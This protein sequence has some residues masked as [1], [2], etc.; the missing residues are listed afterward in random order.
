[1][2]CLAGTALLFSACSEGDNVIDE[3][4]DNETRGGVIRTVSASSELPI[5]VSDAGF[6]GVFE[7][8][9]QE[10]G[11]LADFVEVYVGFRDND[12]DKDVAQ[13]LYETLD[14][15]PNNPED[16]FFIGE[17]G[18]PRF[19][20]EL[21]LAEMLGFTGVT[22]ADLFGGGQFEVRF[23]LVLNDG[24]RYSFADNTGTLTGSFFRSPFLYTPT[25]ICPIAADQFVGEY[26]LVSPTSPIG[27]VPVWNEQVVTLSVGATSTT[28][29]FSAVYLE[30]LAIGNGANSFSFDLVCGTVTVPSGQGSGLGCS[31]TIFFGPAADG[32]KGSY[33][34]GDDSAITIVFAEDE[35]NGCG[36]PVIQ[37]ATLTKVG[38]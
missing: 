16:P 3:I 6:S 10:N 26:V 31:G 32:Q 12:G 35:S 13:S 22:E 37:T 27:G 2:M 30:A 19:T 11:T 14:Y 33:V 21:S 24:R 38:G 1:M 18:Y 9:T 17:Y 34:S 8:Q 4:N 28:R 23:E 5:G 36:G 25:V 7:I 20:Y 15:D 29:T